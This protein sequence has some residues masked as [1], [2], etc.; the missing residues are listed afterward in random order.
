[1]VEIFVLH[2]L[3]LFMNQIFSKFFGWS[4]QSAILTDFWKNW[5][6]D[7]EFEH[8]QKRKAFV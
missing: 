3:L 7:T 1:M 8:F 6:R 4:H 5:S 2:N